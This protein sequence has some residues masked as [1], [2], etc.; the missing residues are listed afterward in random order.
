MAESSG[1]ALP[2]STPVTE[3]RIWLVRDEENNLYCKL[4][5]RYWDGA[6]EASDRHL[7]KSTNSWLT[8]NPEQ[9]YPTW[10]T[11]I[12]WLREHADQQKRGVSATAASSS[13]QVSGSGVESGLAAGT[14]TPVHVAAPTTSQLHSELRERVEL[15]QAEAPGTQEEKVV[16]VRNV[17][18]RMME[19]VTGSQGVPHY[20]IGDDSPCEG[21]REPDPIP[22]VI[23]RRENQRELPRSP[24]SAPIHR[25]WTRYESPRVEWSVGAVPFR[26]F[27][28]CRS[29]DPEMKHIFFENAESDWMKL[30]AKG[31]MFWWNALTEEAFWEA[32]GTTEEPWPRDV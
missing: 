3:V 8:S 17:L 19:V 16:V 30:H 28:W 13:T 26:R 22:E 14:P 1:S 12:R 18:K 4:C 5:G 24:P 21:R 27:W 20:Y 10:P 15:F 11:H 6:H 25:Y 9:W 32:T 29:D 2:G 31:K 23:L 7:Q